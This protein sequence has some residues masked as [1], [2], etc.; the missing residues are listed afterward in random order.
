MDE[1]IEIINTNTRI[2][3]LKNFLISKR[4]QLITS[5]ILIILILITFFGYQEFKSSSKEKLANKFNSI[6]TNFE[7]GKKENINNNLIEI[8]NTKD[9]TYSPLA[10]FFL[11]D[12]DLITSSDEINS[13]FDLLINEV[14]L[15][16]EIKNLTIYK[17]GIFNSDFV[18]ENELLNI[19]NPVIK[20]ESI[21][22]PQALYLMA[23]FYLAKNQKQ[24]SKDFFDQI[25]NIE[26][27]SPKIK[28]EVQRRLRSEFGE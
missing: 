26:N 14:S 2:E 12:N 18:Q 15:D 8:I 9:K 6:V 21:W 4:K 24:K 25:M 17:K 11:L 1:E 20:S 27:V 10:F 23:E 13:Y 19:L 5:L 28:L 16:K 3:K 7:T 22:K